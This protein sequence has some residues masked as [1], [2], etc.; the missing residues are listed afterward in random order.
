APCD[1]PRS[2]PRCR[3][4]ERRDAPWRG[5]GLRPRRARRSPWLPSRKRP[6]PRR[7]APAR[8]SRRHAAAGDRL[9]LV[10]AWSGSSFTRIAQF[11]LI[12]F[13]IDRRGRDALA[14]LLERR[15]APHRVGRALRPRLL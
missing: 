9:L 7:A 12:G 14:I 11:G 2:P 5:G 15:R 1:R 8:C 4:C 3:P 10:F 13:R 6:A